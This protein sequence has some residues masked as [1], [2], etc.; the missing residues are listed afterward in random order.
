MPRLS[1][2]TLLPVTAALIAGCGS[3]GTPGAAATKRS[4]MLAFARCMRTH[5]VQNFPDPGS[6]GSGGLQIQDR[7]GSGGSL[8]VNGT[9][10]S[11]PAFQGAMQACHSKLPNG[12]Q[13]PALSAAQRAAMLKFSQCMRTHG[14]TNFP[15]PSFGPGGAV[16]LRVGP[17]GGLDPNS[18]AFQSAQKACAAY[19]GGAGFFKSDAPPPGSNR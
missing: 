2:L 5:G 12:G 11:S 9:S 13:P 3:S 16:R 1:K 18:P 10:V 4:D 14:L 6:N 17:A 19:R 8:K 7:V 15:D